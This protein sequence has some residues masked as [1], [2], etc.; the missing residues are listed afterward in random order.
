MFRS[1]KWLLSTVVALTALLVALYLPALP[2]PVKASDSSFRSSAVSGPTLPFDMPAGASNKKVFA[3]YFPPY[4]VSFENA[5]PASDYYTTQYLNPNGE[6][7]KHAAYGGLLR[8]RPLTRAPRSGADWRFQDLRQEV[9][10]AMSRG[11]DGFMVDILTRSASSNWIA[12]VPRRLLDAAG[13]TAGK[14]TVTLM[15]DMNGELGSLTP[16]GLAAELSQYATA[17]GVHRLADGR[18]VVSPFYAEKKSVS[19]WNSFLSTMRLRYRTPVAFVPTFLDAPSNIDRFASI[20]YGMS[21][22]GGRNPALNPTVDTGPNS[23]IGVVNR[24][25]R[26]GKLWM[27]PVSFQDSR[28][29]QGIYDE[30][31]NT[32]NLRNTWDIAVASGSEW[33]QLTTW[34][35]YSEGTAFAPSVRHGWA[36]LDVTAFAAVRF[37]FGSYPPVRRP[38]LYLS[39]RTQFADS[40]PTFPERTLMTLRRGSS[41]AR[42]TVEVLS[43]LETPADVV[44]TSGGRQITCAAPAGPGLC[45]APLGAGSVSAVARRGSTVV[46]SVTSPFTVTTS[47]FVQT[48]DYT[49]TGSPR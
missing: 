29:N 38:G 30:A 5:V 35:D 22:W 25:H 40:R 18:L 37:K 11:I 39:H 23:P 49:L 41:P 47:P 15:P 28:P 34:N 19:W 33:V 8:D 27:Q 20:S 21:N 10:D 4:P 46:Q 31:E 13:E 12:S 36:L 17:P 2:D 6:K 3:H 16:A 7:N 1:R 45:L 48:L 32:T 14:F 9:A 42:N 26:L 44:I 24:V 43:F